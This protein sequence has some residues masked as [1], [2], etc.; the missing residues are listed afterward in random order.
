[1]WLAGQLRQTVAEEHDA[2]TE[3]Q[4]VQPNAWLTYYPAEQVQTPAVRVRPPLQV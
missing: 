2:Q 3:G 1:L 4:V